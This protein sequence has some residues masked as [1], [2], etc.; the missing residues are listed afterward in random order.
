MTAEG[1]LVPL[2]PLDDSDAYF[3]LSLIDLFGSG[4]ETAM[5][6]INH[7]HQRIFTALPGPGHRL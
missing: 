3:L 4:I 7:H 5:P 1:E 6:R 2:P